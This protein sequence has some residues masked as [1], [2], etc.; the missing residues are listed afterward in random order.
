MSIRINRRLAL[1]AADLLAVGTLVCTDVSAACVYICQCLQWR[2][3]LQGQFGQRQSW[4]PGGGG[5]PGAL[6]LPL[7]GNLKMM[8]S[9]AVIM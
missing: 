9:Y 4:A 2:Q 7:I 3:Q 8:T 1:D 6:A 5:Q